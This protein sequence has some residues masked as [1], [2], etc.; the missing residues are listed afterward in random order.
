MKTLYII[1]NGFDMAHGLKTSYWNF[2]E[3]LDKTY[4]EFLLQFE[5]LY[6][7]YSPDFSDPRISEDDR[8][9][10][11]EAVNCDLWSDLEK[12]I[13]QPNIS[14]MEDFSESV[15][16]DLDLDSGLIGIGDTMDVYWKREYG[17]VKKFEQYVREWIESVDTSHVIPRRR[18]LIRTEDYFLNFNYTDLLE[19][20]YQ[21]RNVLHIHGG[22][23]SVTSIAPIMG[24]CN[25]IDIEH[26]TNEARKADEKFSEGEASIKRAIASYLQST[27]KDTDSIISSWHSFWDGLKDVSKVVIF[28]WSIGEGDLPYLR[29]IQNS[30]QCDV[31]WDAYYYSEKAYRNIKRVMQIEGIDSGNN[32]NYL[33]ANEFWDF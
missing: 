16:A 15:L 22:V 7:I 5:G 29:K 20:V 33:Q 30:V 8:K 17:Y 26:Y 6:N 4:P 19:N 31:I 13:G 27:Y 23:R 24:H 32:V 14:E 21:N 18:A 3:F 25:K 28:G 9:R 10:W 11:E 12:R 1:G 2:R